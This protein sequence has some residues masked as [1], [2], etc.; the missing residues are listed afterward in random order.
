[1]FH[2]SI[3]VPTEKGEPMNNDLISRKALIEAYDKAHQGPPGGARKLMEEAPAVDAVEVVHGRWELHGNDDD[4]GCSYFCSNCH[5]SYDE[6]WFYVH[7]QY[8]HWNYCPKCGAKM[9]GGK[10]K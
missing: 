1:M 4:C 7:G 10:E 8:R 6:E 2:N 3:I 5:N 9:D